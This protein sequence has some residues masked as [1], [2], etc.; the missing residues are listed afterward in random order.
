MVYTTGPSRTPATTCAFVSTWFGAYTKPEPSILR[1]Q[2]G[3]VPSTF[4]TLTLALC[5]PALLITA[6]AAAFT[7]TTPPPP[8]P[9]K[10][11]RNG[12]PA[13]TR[14]HP[15]NH[16]RPAPPLRPSTP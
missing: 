2:S 9:P 10:N 6:G 3:A 15:E 4:T 5:T 11:R 8:P 1:E 14:P 13:P 12:P 7:H 16:R